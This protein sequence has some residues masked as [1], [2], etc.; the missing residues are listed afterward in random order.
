ML[1]VLSS[2]LEEEGLVGEQIAG[3]QLEK[4]WNL[5][6]VLELVFT[7]RVQCKQKH[8]VYNYTII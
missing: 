4:K 2:I 5:I 1:M 6:N 8:K 3:L 7:N